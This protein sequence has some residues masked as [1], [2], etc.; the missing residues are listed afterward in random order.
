[1]VGQKTLEKVADPSSALFSP[2]A[3]GLSAP[4]EEGSRESSH[5][6]TARSTHL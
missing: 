4:G 6:E 1:M 5:V 3:V 2:G